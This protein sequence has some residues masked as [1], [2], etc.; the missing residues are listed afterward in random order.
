MNTGCQE[1][2]PDRTDLLMFGH[3]MV[4][5]KYGTGC[6]HRIDAVVQQSPKVCRGKK[7]KN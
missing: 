5:R 2:F 1:P 7:L 3:E 6:Y 4:S